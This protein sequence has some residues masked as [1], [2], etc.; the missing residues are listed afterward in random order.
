MAGGGRFIGGIQF[1]VSA[2]TNK[3]AGDLS[4]ARRM[5]GGFADTTSKRIAKMSSMFGGVGSALTAGLSVAGLAAF[6]KQS[7]VA[8]DT[9]NDTSK[10]L[11]VTTDSLS[12]MSFAAKL[13]DGS[14]ESMIAGFE[15]I[16]S[17]SSKAARGVKSATAVYDKLGLSA[18]EMARLAPDAQ[19]LKLSDA[20]TKLQTPVEQLDAAQQIFGR[21]LATD[22]MGS[23]RLGTKGF[24]D[25][26]N[27]AQQAGAVVDQLGADKVSAS[28]D[29]I[30]SMQSALGG[31]GTEL[32]IGVAP[33][34][35]K[36]ANE[37]ERALKAA[38]GLPGGKGG[39]GFMATLGDIGRTGADAFRGARHVA[40]MATAG[41]ASDANNVAQFFGVKGGFLE[42][43]ARNM[44]FA[45]KQTG[46]SFK[47]GFMATTPSERMS[48][49]V[50]N[51]LDSTAVKAAQVAVHPMVTRITDAMSKGFNVQQGLFAAGQSMGAGTNSL[52]A[53]MNKL[54]GWGS[55]INVPKSTSFRADSFTANES[56][57]LAAYQ[58]RV[59]GQ[60]QFEKADPIQK[61][62]LATQKAMLKALERAP[63]IQA[64]GAVH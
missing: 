10:A 7:M 26:A 40:T 27:K 50:S 25:F 64:M 45:E 57:S 61:D 54:K 35:T 42:D 19:F 3:L 58:Q 29:A 20:V 60:Q 15:R 34:V 24:G 32:A 53:M 17:F 44:A 33:H 47:K 41:F 1:G 62:Q 30:T 63:V 31:V 6:T 14:Q 8:I 16:N 43:F 22:L 28:V 18:K 12:A 21:N 11:G 38:R 13:N 9:L 36:M 4:K 52:P 5:V 49:P 46:D 51:A 23:L 59:R 37:F 56:G 55:G 39:G 48:Q 2:S